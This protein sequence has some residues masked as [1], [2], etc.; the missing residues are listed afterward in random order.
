MS[1]YGD[2]QREPSRQRQ[3]MHHSEKDGIRCR[4]TA[5]HNE[6]MCFHHRQDEIPTVLQN[7]PFEIVHLED[8][9]AIQLALA[10][11]AARLACNHMDFKRAALILQALQ[12]AS[13]NLTAR[14][15]LAAKFP[16]GPGLE[17]MPQNVEEDSTSP[18]QRG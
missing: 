7:D 9:A 12:I 8:R 11:T 4:S 15:N 18:R 3:C 10:D 16:D 6:I 1:I 13:H 5:M 2:Y 14:E 17:A